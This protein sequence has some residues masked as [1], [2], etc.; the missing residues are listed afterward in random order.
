MNTLR[1]IG[2]AVVAAFAVQLVIAEPPQ[3]EP[4]TAE[5]HIRR[6]LEG[7]SAGSAGDM[8]L[9][10]VLQ[11]IQRRGS[12]LDGS[13]LDESPEQPSL[14]GQAAA[15]VSAKAF[16]AEQLLKA[17]RLVEKVDA[18]NAKRVQLVSQMRA[19]ARKLLSE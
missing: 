8:V 6:V 3:S 11:V 1:W 16:A 18:E 5:Q 4:S 17:A 13:I 10:D 14:S 19:E 9:D 2:L 15:T 12:I 7:D